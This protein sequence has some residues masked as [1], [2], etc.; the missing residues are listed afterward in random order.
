[1]GI[2]CTLSIILDVSKNK[3]I[4]PNKLQL[5]NYIGFGLGDLAF[6]LFFQGVTLFLLFFYTDILGIEASI[7]GTIFLVATIWDAISDP[8]VGW[9]ASNTRSRW[10]RYR[11]YLLWIPIPL[12]ISYVLLFY[13]PDLEGWALI[14]WVSFLQIL[15]RTNFTL[16]NIPYSSLSS[17]MTFDP[18]E[19][20]TLAMYRMFL[21]YAGALIVSVGTGVLMSKMAWL[22][23]EDGYWRVA[24]IAAVVS[25][26]LF[27]ICFKSTFELPQKNKQTTLKLEDALGMIRQNPPFWKLNLFVVVGMAGVVL[28]YQSL[29][30]YFKY[31][32]N[33]EAALGN[34][35]L[36]LFIVL[37]LAL[38]VWLKLTTLFGK[39]KTLMMGCIVLMIGSLG[40]YF[41]TLTNTSITL[42]YCYLSILGCGIG[43]MGFSFWAMLPDTVEYGEWKTGVRAEA[44]I[45]GFG[46]FFLKIGLGIGSFVL[47]LLLAYFGYT[48]NTTQTI[49]TLNGLHALTTLA[50][51]FP[52]LITLGIMLTYSLSASR[53]GEILREL[54]K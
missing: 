5:K 38:P 21:G 3:A 24:I 8:I 45:F 53:Y 39:P 30:Y 13:Q 7:A 10:G 51:F 43:C 9:I 22:A 29:A 28:L 23:E 11:G 35:M 52:A 41:H 46:L 1:M 4:Q 31:N 27:Y 44:I 20:S 6:N 37:M 47:G 26:I 40:F 32:L 42:T 14:A 15:F 50:L 34:G 54:D 17:E 16:A 19:R 49:E 33:N 36:Y 12:G 25:A 18:V 48:P 2:Y